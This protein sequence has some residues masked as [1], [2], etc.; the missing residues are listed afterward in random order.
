MPLLLKLGLPPVQRLAFVGGA[1][2]VGALGTKVGLD[3]GAAVSRNIQI[4]ES[5]KKSAHAN[6]NVDEI[7]SPTDSGSNVFSPWEDESVPL[8]DLIDNLFTLNVLE[9]ILIILVVYFLYQS[10]M[11]NVYNFIINFISKYLPSLPSRLV[12]RLTSFFYLNKVLGLFKTLT[13]ILQKGVTFN[14]NIS[15]IMI[16][17]IF[18]TII[19]FILIQMYITDNL[20]NNIDDYVLVYNH[21]KKN[22]LIILFKLNFNKNINNNINYSTLNGV[23]KSSL[24]FFLRQGSWFSHGSCRHDQSLQK[25]G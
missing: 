19:I 8:L 25:L 22:S 5:I 24:K 2:A 9:L 17:L 1:A 10:S 11:G 14:K 12:S 6:T 13:K 7:P 15:K 23:N 21:I 16:V 4:T 20:N 3:A 18:I